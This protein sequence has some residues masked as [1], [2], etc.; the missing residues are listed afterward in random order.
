MN[1]RVVIV[2]GGLAGLAAAAGMATAGVP[3]TLLE[4][5]PR[6]GGRAG[7]FLD[8]ET[9]EW[10]D[11]C[12]HVSMGCC[13]NLAHFAR[14]TG[15]ADLFATQ[16][17][18]L[19]IGPGGERCRFRDRPR[20]APFHLTKAFDSLTWFS[21]AERRR[22]MRD[23]A[24]LAHRS[25]A[26][27]HGLSFEQWLDKHAQTSDLR[28][29]FWDVIL[30]S[31]LS[32]SAGRISVPHARK[33]FV[34]GFLAH[35]DGWRVQIPTVPL[36][37]LYGRRLTDWLSQ[38]GVSVTTGAGVVGLDEQDGLVTGVRLRSGEQIPADEVILAVPWHRVHDLLPESLADDP[39]LAGPAELE[40]APITS[41]HLWFDRPVLDVPHAV[42]VGRLS[43]W[44]FRRAGIQSQATDLAVPSAPASL[45]SQ[46]SPINH[47]P[48]TRHPQPA[49]HAAQP[50]YVQVVISASHNV[51]RQS[52][53]AVIDQVVSELAAIWPQVREAQ[54][55]SS[56]VVTEHR[57]VFS[58][59]P[60]VDAL[61]P[62]QST[63]IA[64]LQ[65]AGDWTQTGWPA[66][67]E[68]AVKSGF[69]AAANTLARL[70]VPRSL[71]Q[72]PLKPGWLAR[73]LLRL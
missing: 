22:L 52:Q 39:K 70:G 67:M 41:V 47:Q 50:D 69:L 24:R 31:A 3:A 73:L 40:S 51:A 62:P 72:P 63:P 49:S 11:T 14:L 29:R 32:E 55:T 13:T 25:W 64:N 45:D 4:S 53:I 9:G 43:Q 18:L 34:D 58:P 61:R 54:L 48:S 16:Q 38:R 36:D 10:I 26:V 57:A 19:F 27:D 2:G 8:A 15:I 28:E 20:P 59:R 65:L 33:V 68:S 60:G 1:P 23:V 37:E 42:V 56:R 12:Q 21:K 66:T 44:V 7:S 46:P 35:R 30:V 5:R 6:L 17:E 71:V